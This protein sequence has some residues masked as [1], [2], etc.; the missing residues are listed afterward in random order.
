MKQQQDT[1]NCIMK[2][3]IIYNHRKIIV[4]YYDDKMDGPGSMNR[5]EAKCMQICRRKV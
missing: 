2:S 1:E 3:L 5:K 4:K